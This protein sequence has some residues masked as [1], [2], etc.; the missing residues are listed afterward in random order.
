MAIVE[1]APSIRAGCELVGI[2][3]S[4]YYDWLDRLDREGVEGLIPRAGSSVPSKAS[5]AASPQPPATT[6]ATSS[7]ARTLCMAPPPRTPQATPTTNPPNMDPLDRSPLRRRAHSRSDRSGWPPPRAVVRCCSGARGARSPDPAG[8]W[9][10]TPGPGAARTRRSVA[11]TSRPPGIA[12]PSARSFPSS[13]GRFSP[14]VSPHDDRR[15]TDAP[16]TGAGDRRPAG[17]ALHSP[18]EVVWPGRVGA[19]RG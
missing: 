4:T 17:A 8:C 3:H 1:G 5:C 11:G 15:R 18:R 13:A 6:A 12:V 7:T 2:H 14:T 10:A 9:A 16:A 19:R